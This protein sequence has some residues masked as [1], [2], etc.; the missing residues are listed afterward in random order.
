MGLDVK[1]NL[2]HDSRKRHLAGE[3]RDGVSA[4]PASKRSHFDLVPG[5]QNTTTK[6]PMPRP[7]DIRLVTTMATKGKTLSSALTAMNMGP[8]GRATML[9][10]LTTRDVVMVP[11]L[12]EESSGFVMPKDPWYKGDGIRKTIYQRLVEEIYHA[13]KHEAPSHSGG[14]GKRGKGGKGGFDDLCLSTDKDGQFKEDANGLFKA[15]HKTTR[16]AAGERPREEP[17]SVSTRADG[18]N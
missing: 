5:D 12:F 9:Q 2:L 3:G 8:S 13:G 1:E 14:G 18:Q 16:D 7:P 4:F 10:T 17:Q 15:W 6:E 11:D